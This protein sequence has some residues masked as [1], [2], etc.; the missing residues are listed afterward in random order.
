MAY[1]PACFVEWMPY[2][3]MY[4]KMYELQGSIRNVSNPCQGYSICEFVWAKNIERRCRKCTR[5][6]IQTTMQTS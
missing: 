6:M 3:E 4:M 2:I 1:F 5:K